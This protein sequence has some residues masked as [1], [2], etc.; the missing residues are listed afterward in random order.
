MQGAEDGRC[1]SAFVIELIELR[2]N[3]INSLVNSIDHPVFSIIATVIMRNATRWR[4]QLNSDR[5]VCLSPPSVA[6]CI[7][8]KRCT[9]GVCCVQKS[10]RTAGSTL[11][12]VAFSTP[13][14]TN[15]E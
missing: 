9:I 5:S 3:L 8:A 13:G 1:L 6:F 7:V 2:M 14:S 15:H 4:F 11:R 12:L 10:N